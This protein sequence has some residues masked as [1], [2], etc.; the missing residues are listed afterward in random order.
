MKKRYV[1]L[2]FLASICCSYGQEDLGKDLI[3]AMTNLKVVASEA[4]PLAKDQFAIIEAK[5]K[6]DQYNDLVARINTPVDLSIAAA[7]LNMEHFSTW[8]EQHDK[9]A[10][11]VVVLSVSSELRALDGV[12]LAEAIAGS[13]RERELLDLYQKEEV[14]VFHVVEAY[15]RWVGMEH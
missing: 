14:F 10:L 6:G 3:E 5:F 8:V 13:R 12:L 7:G 9:N 15:Q 1:I 2:L 4:V 11:A